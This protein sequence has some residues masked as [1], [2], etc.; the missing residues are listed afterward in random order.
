M[1]PLIALSLAIASC[2]I[3]S[4]ATGPNSEWGPC[5]LN[6]HACSDHT[7]CLSDWDCGGDTPGCPAN[8]CCYAGPDVLYGK[9][10]ERTMFKRRPTK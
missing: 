1:R 10:E 8:Q 9:S 7:C 5:R 6:E 4:P 3:L 2:A